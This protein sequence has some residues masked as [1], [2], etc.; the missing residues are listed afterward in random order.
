[1]NPSSQGLARIVSVALVMNS[2]KYFL[3]QIVNIILNV[4]EPFP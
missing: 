1:M 3:H 2:K 4:G